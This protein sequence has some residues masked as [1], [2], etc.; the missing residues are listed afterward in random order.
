M[1]HAASA[2][3]LTGEG[4]LA[5]AVYLRFVRHPAE[6]RLTFDVEPAACAVSWRF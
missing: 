6:A 3:L 5:S 2:A 4:L 1:D